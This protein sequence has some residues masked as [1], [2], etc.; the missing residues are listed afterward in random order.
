MEGD[1]N[2]ATSVEERVC[3]KR[4]RTSLLQSLRLVR[5]DFQGRGVATN[6]A[7]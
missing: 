6:R 2:E 5:D 3:S 4:F 7:F 1:E